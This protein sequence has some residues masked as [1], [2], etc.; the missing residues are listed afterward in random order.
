MIIINLKNIKKIITGVVAIAGLAVL[1]GC[2]SYGTSSTPANNNLPV[3]ASTSPQNNATTG[4][5]VMI[6]N[7]AFSPATLTVKAGTT[8]TWTNN[9]SATHTI[10]S[11]TFNSSNLSTGDKFQFTFTVPGT[12][13]YSCGIHPSMHGVIIVQ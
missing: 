2:S 8:V 1:A 13:N 5:A 10:K 12:F 11:D 7:F 4:S 3:P 6:Q 9:D